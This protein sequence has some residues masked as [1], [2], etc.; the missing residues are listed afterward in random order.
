MPF[1][2]FQAEA[3]SIL[4]ATTGFIAQAGFTHSLTPARNCTFGCSYCYVP[5]HANLRRPE[6]GRLAPL[7]P[8]HDLQ[9][10]R[11]GIAEASAPCEPRSFIVRRWWILISPPKQTEQ[12]MPRI[13]DQLLARPPKLF[14]VQ[15][16]GPLI[17]RDLAKL[18]ELSR[19]TNVRVSFS[20][21]T[22]REDVRRTLRAALR[23]HRAAPRDGC[24]R[25]ATPES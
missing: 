3:A 17:V 10:Q 7:G 12:L 18:V 25:C 4:S 20:L 2:V 13:L 8:V 24:A 16:R 9:V 6:A 21:T 23:P 15:T 1:Q 19:R 11:A 14:V 5:D 22:D